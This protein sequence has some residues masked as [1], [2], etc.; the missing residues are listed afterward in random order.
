M[1]DAADR[2][3]AAAAAAADAA[4]GKGKGKG[5]KVPKFERLRLTGEARLEVTTIRALLLHPCWWL[6]TK[7]PCAPVI[8]VA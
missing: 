1:A 3:E 8:L 6:F 4:G 7:C 2:A 5:K